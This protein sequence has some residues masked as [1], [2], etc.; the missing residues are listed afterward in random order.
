MWDGGSVCV[1]QNWREGVFGALGWGPSALLLTC[2][3]VT[4][5]RAAAPG[6]STR[7]CGV[8]V[9]FPTRLQSLRLLQNMSKSLLNHHSSGL[10]AA[11][12]PGQVLSPPGLLHV[13]EEISTAKH[14]SERSRG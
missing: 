14:P 10:R 2:A 1:S 9:W 8:C 4:A 13:L 7:G 6:R 11:G 3:A 5:Q 12:F